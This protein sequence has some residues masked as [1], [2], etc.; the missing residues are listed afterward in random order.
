MSAPNVR[1]VPKE[2]ECSGEFV[3][4]QIRCGTTIFTPPTV[5]CE[6]LRVRLRCGSNGKGHRRR[7]N[8]SRIFVAVRRRPASADRHE[9]DSVSCRARRSSSVRSSPSSSATKS[10]TVPSGKVVGSS[11]TRRPFSTRALRGFMTPTVR[12]SRMPR[13]PCDSPIGT[14]KTCASSLG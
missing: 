1:C 8:S 3:C 13:K 2:F 12:D 11:R 5:D 6:D 9:A 10:T 7:R 14:E 4:E